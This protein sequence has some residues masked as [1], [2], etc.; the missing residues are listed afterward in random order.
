MA[1]RCP[2]RRAKAIRSRAA[3]RRTRR[4][5]QRRR[6]QQQLNDL[7]EP[8]HRPRCTVAGSG[9]A[10]WR[11]GRAAAPF[12]HRSV[13]AG[14]AAA[15]MAICRRAR[16]YSARFRTIARPSEA[17][18]RACAARRAPRRIAVVQLR[19]ERMEGGRGGSC[20]RGARPHAPPSRGAPSPAPGSTPAVADDAVDGAAAPA[21][22]RI[23]DRDLRHDH[24][25]LAA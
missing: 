21:P 17:P 15:V 16:R 3:N 2:R 18:R 6:S 8:R 1:I 24:A 19:D 14:P 20:G 25:G 11:A 4:P 7:I 23:A 13:A 5:R 12:R 10:R 22:A 9:A